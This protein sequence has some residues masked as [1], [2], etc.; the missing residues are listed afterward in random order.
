MALWLRGMFSEERELDQGWQTRKHVPYVA[1]NKTFLLI[2]FLLDYSH[3]YY[4][5]WP[6]LLFCQNNRV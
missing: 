6:Q 1:H 3:A 2:K 4:C 5:T